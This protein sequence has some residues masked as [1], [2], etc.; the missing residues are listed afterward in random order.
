MSEPITK[1]IARSLIVYHIQRNTD[2]RGNINLPKE[3]QLIARSRHFF[4]EI[5]DYTWKGLLCIAYDLEPVKTQ[6]K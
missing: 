3:D 2:E 5:D 4:Y 6:D 1:D